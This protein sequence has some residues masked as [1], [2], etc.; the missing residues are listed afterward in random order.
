MRNCYI[1]TFIIKPTKD[2]SKEQ[3]SIKSPPSIFES[4]EYENSDIKSKEN[5]EE[6]LLDYMNEKNVKI[7][8]SMNEIYNEFTTIK[9]NMRLKKNNKETIIINLES[10]HYNDYLLKK[11]EIPQLISNKVKLWIKT[12]NINS[13]NN[14][15]K[16]N[17][18]S[19]SKFNNFSN[20]F[21]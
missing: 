2:N 12:D 20:A 18:E 10:G 21:T 16:Y 13:D 6:Q 1:S 19:L 9:N 14:T 17:N 11:E 8:N 5:F 4:L 3:F 7:E 15:D